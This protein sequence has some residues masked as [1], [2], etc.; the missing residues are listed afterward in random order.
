MKISTEYIEGLT[1]YFVK[2][3]EQINKIVNFPLTAIV[4]CYLFC[5]YFNINNYYQSK[6][7]LHKRRAK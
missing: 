4:L 7:W 1:Q 6:Y 3:K 2:S 5:I